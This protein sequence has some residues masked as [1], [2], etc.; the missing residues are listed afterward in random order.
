MKTIAFFGLKGGVGRTTIVYNLAWMLAERGLRVLAVD[1]DP[2]ANLTALSL[3]EDRAMALWTQGV[4]GTISAALAPLLT[5]DTGAVDPVAVVPQ[6]LSERLELLPGDLNLFRFEDLLGQAWNDC[7]LDGKSY[8]AFNIT[9]AFNRLIR[10]RERDVDVALIDLS[11]GL[12]AI[13]RAG[14]L[15][16]DYV[17]LPLTPD[18]FSV[19]SL[20]TIGPVLHEW[21]SVWGGVMNRWDLPPILNEPRGTMEPA[22]YILSRM[23]T[24]GGRPVAAHMQ[25]MERIPAAYAGCVTHEVPPPA[26]VDD[27]NCLARIKNYPS[28]AAMAQDAHKPIFLL[29]PGDG[30]SGGYLK[31]AQDSYE[32]F[33]RL[34][35]CV[36]SRIGLL[37]PDP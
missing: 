17:V 3:G 9:G 15:A 29:R 11:P 23:A 19:L 12:S 7:V 16:A 4:Y 33:R 36:A 2:Q 18:P 30:A 10:A 25:S 21:R 5:T 24:M 28:L 35:H 31:A 6:P 8:Q 20:E 34:A 22:G 14:L 13:N 1:L 37:L 32:E 26:G 27:S